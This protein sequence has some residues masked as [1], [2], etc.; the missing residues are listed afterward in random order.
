MVRDLLCRES[1]VQGSRGDGYVA[2]MWQLRRSSGVSVVGRDVADYGVDVLAF[3]VKVGV[4][5]VIGG[6]PD[7]VLLVPEH[8][9]AVMLLQE[10]GYPP[11]VLGRGQAGHV[12]AL[13]RVARSA[14]TG[15]SCPG[16]GVR[17]MRNAAGSWP[18]GVLEAGAGVLL[19]EDF[20]EPL[21]ELLAH[22]G[23]AREGAKRVFELAAVVAELESSQ[24]VHRMLGRRDRSGVCSHRRS[25]PIGACGRG[26]LGPNVPNRDYGKKVR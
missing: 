3:G 11:S 18:V 22:R 16:E 12:I 14:C 19:G 13:A 23:M 20:D 26:D 24:G 2:G 6:T 10:T 15:G 4:G 8:G 21:L 9:P 5:V 25:D 7:A 1:R 17:A